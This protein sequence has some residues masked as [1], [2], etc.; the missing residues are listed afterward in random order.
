MKSNIKEKGPY[1]VLSSRE[2]YK[3]SWIHVR[4]DKVIHPGGKEGIFGIIEM[5]RGVAILPVNAEQEVYLVREY[6]YGA[7]KEIIGLVGGTVENFETS[8][9]A[10]KRELKEETGLEA[11][12]WVNLGIFDAYENVVNSNN[13]PLYLALGLIEGESNPDESERLTVLKV[14]LSQA[15]EMVLNNSITSELS[16][17][18]I[19]M[20]DKYF[21]K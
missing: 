12:E 6:K 9:D 11:Q 20:A 5:T 3:N 21:K 19:L 4:E 10:A 7:G 15:I 18:A 17:L 13:L 1:K 14:P 16:G 2:I 8:L